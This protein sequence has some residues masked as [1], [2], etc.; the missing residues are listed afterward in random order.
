M[1]GREGWLGVPPADEPW[2]R[3]AM[4][5]LV[6]CGGW[7]LSP[8]GSRGVTEP[9]A[10][11]ARAEE[12]VSDEKWPGGGLARCWDLTGGPQAEVAGAR[13]GGVT[14]A[15][16]LSRLS[17][18]CPLPTPQL[19]LPS[20]QL[21][22]HPPSLPGQAWTSFGPPGRL[23]EGAGQASAPFQLL[24]LRLLYGLP[25]PRLKSYLFNFFLFKNHRVYCFFSIIWHISEA[26]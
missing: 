13:T 1:R 19:P 7:L 11:G 6:R 12:E 26:H 10:W 15:P 2:K 8:C 24:T 17:R 22:F 14:L 21:G 5:R 4:L 16:E 18:H 9:A 25:C 3:L 23:W 20:G